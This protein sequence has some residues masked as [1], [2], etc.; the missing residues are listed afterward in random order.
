MEFSHDYDEDLIAQFFATVH[1]KKTNDCEMT[2]MTRDK[3]MRGTWAQFRECL[4]YSVVQNPEGHG[5]FC[6]HME[7]CHTEKKHLAH[8]Y[9]LGSGIL[10]ESK[11]FLPVYDIMHHIYREM[12]NPKARNID[13]IHGFMIDLLTLTQ[14][15]RGIGLKIDVMDFI[16]NEIQWA[17]CYR[18][19]PPYA[20]YW[21]HFI[22][23]WLDRSVLRRSPCI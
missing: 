14:Q 6:A 12:F 1:L 15:K 11:D 22:C 4:G 19:R 13:E 10:G 3:L 18:K 20:L 23:M 17:I 16:W 21:M 5:L 8:L 7:T 9:I 2:W